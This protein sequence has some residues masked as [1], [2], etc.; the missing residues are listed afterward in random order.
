MQLV[1]HTNNRLPIILQ[2]P[3]TFMDVENSDIGM[4]SQFVSSLGGKMSRMF[5]GVSGLQRGQRA[6]VVIVDRLF[7]NKLGDDCDEDDLN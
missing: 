3:G 5:K 2:V 7:F 1:A 4:A 6:D